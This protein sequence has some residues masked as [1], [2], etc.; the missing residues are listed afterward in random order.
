VEER[1]KHVE[2][3]RKEIIAVIEFKYI[4]NNSKNY[5]AEFEKD[6]T[7]LSLGRKYQDF[8]AYNLAFCN[9]K[10]FYLDELKNKVEK[11]SPEVISM[12]VRSYFEGYKKI[13]HK[14]VANQRTNLSK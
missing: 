5:I 13:A 1:S 9:H 8:E 10:Y 6:A 4:I 14:V 11:T 2:N 3:F 12:L 7:K